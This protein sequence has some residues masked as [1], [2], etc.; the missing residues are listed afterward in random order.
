MVPLSEC[1]DSRCPP[2]FS[3]AAGLLATAVVALAASVARLY[4]LAFGI[5]VAASLLAMWGVLADI[6]GNSQLS[7]RK[8]TFALVAAA[9]VLV[10][11]FL[12]TLILI[13]SAGFLP[14]AR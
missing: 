8:K 11:P 3:I 6:G 2:Q 13:F 5:V 4:G 12:F 10:P 1:D 9:V 14:A 7:G